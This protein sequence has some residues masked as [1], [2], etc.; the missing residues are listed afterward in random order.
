MLAVGE[1]LGQSPEG[2]FLIQVHKQ[3]G[4]DL[5]HPLAIAHLLG[6]HKEEETGSIKQNGQIRGT[7]HNLIEPPHTQA[8]T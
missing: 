5:T 2:I 4:S 1:E 8:E 7:I 6:E 3:D